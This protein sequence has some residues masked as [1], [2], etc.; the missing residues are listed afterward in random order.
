MHERHA[1]A[2]PVQS[3]RQEA[4]RLAAL[5][6]LRLLDTPPEERFDRI[7][8]LA[9]RLF[10]AP[11][12][13]INL[14]D[15]DRQWVKS[16]QSLAV[17]ETPRGIS[18]CAHAILDDG[19]LV[20]ADARSDPRFAANPLV[21]GEPFIRFYVGQPLKSPDGHRVGT[22]CVLDR[23]PRQPAAADLAALRDLAAW[24]E[25]ELAAMPIAEALARGR[26][27]EGGVRQVIDS[28]PDGIITFDARGLITSC[29][30]AA[31][32]IFG[33]RVDQLA[34]RPVDTLTPTDD[35][36]GQARRLF[37]RLL[38][39]TAGGRSTGGTG[40]LDADWIDGELPDGADRI[41]GTR[42]EVVGRRGDGALFPMELTLSAM[43]SGEQRLY[44]A[45][46][47]DITARKRTEAAL[48]RSDAR[49]ATVFRASPVAV[50][51]S[52]LADG[53]YLDVNDAFLNLFG[54]A[55]AEVVGQRAAELG[56]W[57]D[58]DERAR[59]MTQLQAHGRLPSVETRFAAKNGQ[60]R[61]MLAG[62]QMIE[63]AG[64]PCVVVFLLDITA[65]KQVEV[66]QARALLAQRAAN[67]QLVRL[68]K[69]K[70]DFVSIVS[71]EF[72]T[73]LTSIQGFS[74][75]LR[76]EALDDAE[77][78]DYADEINRAAQRLG[79]MINEM[80]D[81]DR[82]ES[83]RQRLAR[84]RVDLNGLIAE[85]VAAARPTAPAHAIR[86]DLD[87]TLPPLSADRDK[88]TQVLANLMSNAVKY[89]PDGGEIVVRSRAEGETAHV[90]I[91][92]QGIGV[93]PDGLDK[94]FEPYYRIEAGSDRYV[95]GTGLGLAISR[96]IVAL[97]GGRIWPESVLGRGTTFHIT[98]PLAAPTAS[99]R[100]A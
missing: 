90:A 39:R 94:L 56:I 49:L 63:L 65:R 42:R 30:P 34:G 29:N 31:E 45:I 83:G 5:S 69:T 71:H 54:Y 48:R 21:T 11:I 7:T 73:A 18:F 22:L 76:D 9:R 89:S 79:R 70:S 24:A 61:D 27:S 6:R 15:A 64:E 72:R 23:A 44:L 2:A 98:L 13:V 96:Q 58:A 81:L 40:T 82:M 28:V 93:P 85:V 60:V 91:Q 100:G 41:V 10:D 52:R 92:D 53:L 67:E 88:L 17:T 57:L 14:V 51:I 36:H 78:R 4:E 3:L 26:L 62:V 66:E 74:E 20:I 47:R 8:R 59:L 80:L 55:R 43:R 84:E 97:H 32:H 46:V 87:P 77:T 37:A 12:A 75:L 16:C 35:Q 50:S 95:R 33:R 86:L 99:G 1:L 19:P 25:H 68:N 38:A